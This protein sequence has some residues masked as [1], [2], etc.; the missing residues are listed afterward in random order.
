VRLFTSPVSA[1]NLASRVRLARAVLA[2]SSGAGGGAAPVLSGLYD[3][4]IGPARRGGALRAARRLIVVPQGALTYLPFAALSDESNSRYLV[5]DFALTYLPSAAALPALRARPVPARSRTVGR[6]AA[7]V[8]APDPETLPASRDEA[9]AVG[10]TLVGARRVVGR[11]ATEARL[12]EA[13]A[14]AAVVHVAGHGVMNATNPMFSHLELARGS[15]RSGDDG[16]LEVHEVLDV[17]VASTLVFLSGC[18]TGLGAAWSTGFVS[19]EDYATLAQAFLY[20]GARNVVA[21]LWRVQDD[22]AAALAERFYQHLRSV[23]PAEA[24]AAAQ[25]EMLA[26]PRYHAPYHWAAYSLNG[27]GDGTPD[28]QG[29][30]AVSVR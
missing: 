13:L 17:P 11:G 19:G 21:T 1:D 18:E 8:L 5:Q 16:R 28:A 15:G 27:S 7:V 4:L 30:G 29:R 24:L 20:A 6:V 14:G 26:N 2:D 3:A 9:L 22:G 10:R 23:S 12:R 25:R